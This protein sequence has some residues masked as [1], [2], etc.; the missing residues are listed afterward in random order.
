M[1]HGVMVTGFEPF[2]NHHSNISQ[3]IVDLISE[4]PRLEFKISTSILSVD[5]AGSREI[6]GR[7]D[8]GEEIGAILH[9]GLAEN[10]N[11]ILLERF[12]KNQFNMKIA[13]NSGRRLSSGEISNGQITLE[14]K[15]P[16]DFIKNHLR[17]IS[18]IRWND[19]AGGF[20]CNETYFRSLLACSKR[21]LPIVLFAHLPSEKVIPIEEQYEIVILICKSLDQIIPD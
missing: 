12:A 7:L 11:E 6:S 18:R 2:S 16:R 4:D 1:H 17:D 21:E 3:K 15:V 9:L 5:E 8:N 13:D 19:D 14:T 20:V 10:S